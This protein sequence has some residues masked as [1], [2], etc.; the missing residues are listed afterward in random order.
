MHLKGEV[1]RMPKINRIRIVNFSYNHDSRHILDECFDFHGGDNALLNLANGGGK[2]VLV[3]MFL[4]PIVPEARIQGRN[5]ASFFRRQKLPAYIMIEWKLDGA[6]GY[7]LTGICITAADAAE[8]EGRTRIRY[9]TFTSKYMAANAFDIMRIPLIERRG[10]IIEVKPLREA[11]RIMAERARKD[12][13]LTGYFPD[14]E[15]TLYA[16]HLAEFG[17]SQDEWRNIIT[18]MNDSENGLEDLFQKFKSSS[19]LLDEW[20]LKTVEKVMFKGRSRQ[21]LEEM[22]QSLVRE[23]IENERFIME[24]QLI[25]DFLASFQNVSDGL[26]I[27]LKNLEEQ[28]QLGENLAALHLHLGSKIKT[29]QEEQQLNTDAI[30]KARDDIRK[31]EL[32]ERSHQYH[33]SLTRHQETEKILEACEQSVTD[34][35]N[36]LKQT[37]KREKILQAAGHAAD[38]RRQTSELS[39]IEERLAMARE[40][41]DKDD[42]VARLEYSLQVKCA[43]ELASVTAELDGLQSAQYQQQEKAEKDKTRLKELETE[44]SQLDSESGK[45]QERLNTFAGAEKQLQ[46]SLGLFWNRNLLGELD[47]AE[48]EMIQ[49]TLQNNLDHC[50]AELEKLQKDKSALQVKLSEGD[51]SRQK[52]NNQQ[53]AARS[54]LADNQR[55]LSEYEAKQNEVQ[56]I[57]DNYGLQEPI[58]Y[59]QT[60]LTAFFT[61]YRQELA[62]NA[63]DAAQ[64][65]NEAAGALLSIRN[66]YLHSSPELAAALNELDIQYETGESYLRNQPPDLRQTLLEG[67]PLLPYTFIMPRAD[68]ERLYQLNPEIVLRRI[69]PLIAYEE[70]NT[71]IENRGRLARPQPEIILACYYEDRIFDNDQRHTLI[72]EMENREKEACQRYEHYLQAQQQTSIDFSTCQRFTYP[73]D[74]QY[75]RG[76]D[77]KTAEDAL[78]NLDQQLKENENARRQGR[79]RL[80]QLEQQMQNAIGK[81]PPAEN[82]LRD[83]LDFLKKEPEYQSARERLDKI[84]SDA[85]NL[86]SQKEFLQQSLENLQVAITAG[87][88]QILQRHKYAEE[89]KH[90]LLIYQR[91]PA[92]DILEGSITEL[93]NRLNAIKAE[94]SQDIINL[95]QQH[96][97]LTAQIRKVQK[98][99][100][101]LE[102]PAA[103][104]LAVIFD[105]NELDSVQ[106][107]ITR[108]ESELKQMQTEKDLSSREEAAAAAALSHA[109]EEVKRLGADEP[110]PAHQTKGDF[111]ARS[112]RLLQQAEE[113]ENLNSEIYRQ[114][115]RLNRTRENIEQTIE[116]G[117]FEP[118]DAFVPAADEIAQAVR[119]EKD[120]RS[121]DSTNRDKSTSLRSS[122]NN[123]KM[124]FK[125]KNLNLDNIFK[126]I[127]P[128]WY[129]ARLNYE[130]YY[131][132]FE[133]MSQHREKLNELIA[134]YE[135]QLA[136][137]QRNK[138]D[139][140]Q[141]SFLQGRRLYEEIQAISE[142]S[143]V[144]LAGRSRPVQ[145]LRIDLQ[146]DDHESALQ[147]INDYIEACILKVQDKA[148]QD[149]SDDELRKT[150][151]RLMSSRELINIYLGNAHIPIYVYKIDMNMQNSRAKSWEDAVRENSG[152]E[153]FVVFFSMLSALI[154]YTRSRNMESIGADPDT[155]TRVMIMDNPFGPISSEHLLEPMFEIAKKHRTQLICLTHLK[156]NSIMKRFNLIYML[157]VRMSAAGG[158]EYLKAEQ[159]IRDHSLVNDDEKLEKA[160]YRASELTETSLFED[161]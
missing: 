125:D 147:R 60:K 88:N 127:D 92:A 23:V 19:Q 35:E 129:K 155:D 43:A 105:E 122:Y 75:Q 20:I 77:I 17:I 29:L 156:D 70:L 74:F 117:S 58:I 72:E 104:Y 39:G 158:K 150:I 138:K 1:K 126:G 48:M 108:L 130:D 135:N 22:L 21:Q 159:Y 10:D 4:Q 9:F 49:N 52:I 25:T 107:E 30:T 3:Q 28:N 98:L 133:R 56:Q 149:S 160:I 61:R 64:I 157:K 26:S 110:L 82:S 27:L 42:R 90:K 113:L 34:G 95:E 37:K 123:C 148:R 53:E 103:D 152:A 15:K 73:A 101:R 100:E 76:K 91:A 146:L 66:H 50:L 141:Q 131:Y 54:A 80:D 112:R 78:F 36:Q 89:L 124:D 139:M 32:E 109:R 38:I 86:I 18:R 46:K 69:I 85:Q 114:L 119:L 142:H 83:W 68:I 31:V 154:T 63:E 134:V 143:K 96:K 40:G 116:I 62:K 14:D 144:R 132:L 11:R 128:L 137:L 106:N 67:N 93:E 57:L 6:G 81:I 44:K 71:I 111:A 55:Q 120:F 16:R 59:D 102:V 99:L 140:V 121:I 79:K 161:E 41:Y 8:P 118:A 13:Y 87:Q 153:R 47:P 97:E 12:P 136:N 94:H 2:S 45:L 33:I 115:S 7:L 65:R 24:K 84:R 51:E 145:M 151:S 5:L